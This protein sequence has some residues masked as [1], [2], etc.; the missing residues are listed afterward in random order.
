MQNFFAEEESITRKYS[1]MLKTVEKTAESQ[2][3]II[4]FFLTPNPII[5][6]VTLYYFPTPDT[7][8][9]VPGLNCST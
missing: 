5:L 4:S 3:V 9:S 2:Y 8:F 6:T 7:E 1:N